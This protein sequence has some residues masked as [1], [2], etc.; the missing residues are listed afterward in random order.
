MDRNAV[1]LFALA[2]WA[3]GCSADDSR[4][5]DPRPAGTDAGS[6]AS[7][8]D[9]APAPEPRTSATQ[10]AADSLRAMKQRLQPK[11]APLATWRA[12]AEAALRPDSGTVR[13][14]SALLELHDAFQDQVRRVART[15]DDPA[16]QALIWP[17][18]V[19]GHQLRRAQQRPLD[20]DPVQIALADSVVTFLAAHGI[21]SYRAEGDTY[22]VASEA[23]VLEWFGR[24]VTG[25]VREFLSLSARE[26]R[27]PTA[28]DGGIRI[29]PDE[30]AARLA[31]A[32]RFLAEHPGAAAHDLVE[33]WYRRYLAVYVAGLPNTPAFD[34]RSGV[35]APE[36]R[37]S[38]EQ[39]VSEHG[40]TASGNVVAEYLTL[41]E[42]S[43]Y[44]RQPPV[45]AYIQALWQA[46]DNHPS[47]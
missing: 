37:R 39:Y 40:G 21:W 35:L 34:W 15:F 19:R 7:V 42:A 17:D 11:L 30:L 25:P 6:T 32:D 31:A 9:T 24:F 28:E 16:F 5:A 38:Y 13:A 10:A 29:T 41:L 36:L 23:A 33:R 3:I 22:F 43:G 2:A 26:Q 46:A 8:A 1:L 18:G 44:R 4:H 47:R 45:D 27:A 20:A 12:A 14:D